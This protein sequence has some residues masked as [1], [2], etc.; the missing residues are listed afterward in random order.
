MRDHIP[1]NFTFAQIEQGLDVQWQKFSFE[2][3]VQGHLE[4]G[5]T[6]SLVILMRCVKIS[7]NDFKLL[8]ASC[9]NNNG[10]TFH[11]DFLRITSIR[12]C[13]DYFELI[14]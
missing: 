8:S 4:P 1:A 5:S 7:P 11:Y 13:L 6:C 3:F 12:L 9:Q 10:H 14:T 2:N